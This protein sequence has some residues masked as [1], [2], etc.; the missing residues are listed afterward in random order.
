MK[1]SANLVASFLRRNVGRLFSRAT[2]AVRTIKYK[3]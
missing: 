1:K 2:K 3:Q